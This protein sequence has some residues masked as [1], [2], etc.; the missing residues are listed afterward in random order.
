MTATATGNCKF[1]QGNGHQNYIDFHKPIGKQETKT[2]CPNCNGTGWTK[3]P[4]IEQWPLQTTQITQTILHHIAQKYKI[5][6]QTYK[7]THI[8]QINKENYNCLNWGTN[9]SLRIYK[10]PHYYIN[11]DAHVHNIILD[12]YDPIDG[13]TLTPIDL[14][15]PHS[16]DKIEQA[17]ARWLQ[18]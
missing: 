12:E 13:S 10:E 14:N 16:L 1:C 17:V 9:P 2:N 11:D 4:D 3:P 8:L 18:K 7:Q 6:D 5:K 15:D